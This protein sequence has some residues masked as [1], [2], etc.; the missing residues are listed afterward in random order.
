[1]SMSMSIL[2]AFATE[3]AALHTHSDNLY[4]FT[5]HSTQQPSYAPRLI[6]CR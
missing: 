5:L 6:D 3:G 2:S 1:M 4:N